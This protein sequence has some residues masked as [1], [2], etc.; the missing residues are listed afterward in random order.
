MNSPRF[1][2]HSYLCRV[3]CNRET[4]PLFSG[5]SRTVA[6]FSV[7]ASCKTASRET[8]PAPFSLTVLNVIMHTAYYD[9]RIP[10]DHFGFSI[11]TGFVIIFTPK[12]NGALIATETHSGIVHR[13]Y[14]NLNFWG[15]WRHSAVP[16]FQGE[17]LRPSIPLFIVIV[18][19]QWIMF[20]LSNINIIR[21]TSSRDDNVRF[22]RE[23]ATDGKNV[24]VQ[25]FPIYGY[26]ESTADRKRG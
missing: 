14:R 12:M 24:S 1:I 21:W 25:Q 18:G 26:K 6:L 2:L 13:N 19:V 11:K 9:T 23:Q 8:L 4:R 10:A 16:A 15:T 3:L 20:S 5:F 7:A 22:A 17:I